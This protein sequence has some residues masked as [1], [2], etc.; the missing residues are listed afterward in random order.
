MHKFLI[1]GV[2][3]QI[4][5]YLLPQLISKYGAGSIIASDISDKLN[6]EGIDSSV[7]YERVDVS[8]FKRIEEIVKSEKVTQIIHLAS[9]LSALGEKYPDLAK[10]VNIDAVVG[11]LDIAKK[12]QVK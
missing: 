2:K 9:I 5:S 10:K 4:G 3:G 6:L 1:T 7:Q 12:Y 11:I 8:E